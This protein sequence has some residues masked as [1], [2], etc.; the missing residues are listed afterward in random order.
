MIQ[1]PEKETW[2]EFLLR[3]FTYARAFVGW[4]IIYDNHDDEDKAHLDML[5]AHYQAG[6]IKVEQ[7][8]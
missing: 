3:E 6:R 5:E 4:P 2:P 7:P 8:K 1:T